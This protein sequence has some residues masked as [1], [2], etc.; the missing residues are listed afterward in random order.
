MLYYYTYFRTGSEY[1]IMKVP[2]NQK[3]FHFNGTHYFLVHADDILWDESIH[4]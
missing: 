3:Q 2:A 4:M 1:A